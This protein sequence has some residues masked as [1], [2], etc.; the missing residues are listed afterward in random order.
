MLRLKGY[1]ASVLAMILA[2][3]IIQVN[4]SAKTVELISAEENAT[5]VTETPSSD[6]SAY[7]NSEVVENSQENDTELQY[8]VDTEV[9]Q[10]TEQE[11]V[12]VPEEPVQTYAEEDSG[13]IEYQNTGDFYHD[14]ESVL[15]DKGY[16]GVLS[17]DEYGSVML[18]IGGGQGE[19]LALLSQM[20][21]TSAY[22]YQNWNISFDFSGNLSLPDT[23]QGLG[24]WGE[25]SEEQVPFKGKFINQALT[26]TTSKTIF[27][28]LDAS[29]DLHGNSI[30]WE[31]GQNESTPNTPILTNILVA[32]SGDHT[33]N[34]P[35]AYANRFNPYIGKL[36][37][38]SGIVTLPSL[39]YSAVGNSPTVEFTDAVGLICGSLSD[40]THLKIGSLTLPSGSINLKSSQSAGS[41]VGC[42]EE[43][44]T[45][46]ITKD[47][48]INSTING[49][50][51]GGIVGSMT[52]ATINFE[53]NVVI[54]VNATLT[55]TQSAGG[56][57][58]VMSTSSGPLGTNVNVVLESVKAN[59]EQNSG[60]LYGTCAATGE[61]NPLTGVTFG[62]TREVSGSGNCG[63][64][65]GE[66]VLSGDGKCIL[67]GT[68]ETN[69][70]IV[71]T[72]KTA[73]NKTAYGGVAGNLTGA[74]ANAIV[75]NNCNITS[76][77][78]VGNETV[79]YPK[80]LGGIVANQSATLDVKNTTVNVHSPKTFR[81]TD[82]GFGGITAYLADNALL[83]A[84]DT[85]VFTDSYAAN[86]GGGGVVGSAHKG[87]IVYLKTKL[88]LSK[89][90]L[91][92]NATSGQIVGS[93]DSSLIYA[94]TV[95]ITRLD[96]TVDGKNV[97]GMELDDI[98]NYGELYRVDGFLTID[99]AYNTSFSRVLNKTDEQYVLNDKYDYAC[100]AL[101]WQSRGYFPTVEGITKDNWYMSS[102]KSSTIT[103]G[104]DIDLTGC[105]IGGLTRD[106]Y[107]TD[108]TFTG[109]FNGGGY[110]LT[111]D[112]GAANT[113]NT[114]NYGDGRIYW[115]NATG[116]F[117]GLSNDAT[118]QNLTLDGSIRL[119][120]NK[121]S[122]MSSGALAAQVSGSRDTGSLLSKVVTTVEYDTKINGG[123][124]LYLGGLIGQISGG[125]AM[126]SFDDG[127]SLGATINISQTG[128]GSYNHFGGAIGGIT[129]DAS[130]YITCSGATITGNIT[131]TSQNGIT[132]LYAGGLIGTILPSSKP[133]NISINNLT[134]KDFTLTGN[135]KER[136]GG[137]LGGIW[138]DTDVTVDGLNV[139]DTTLLTASGTAELGGLVYRA[140]GKWTVS[141]VNLY[142]LTIDASTAG[143]LGILVCHGN[144]Y[145]DPI[146][147]SNQNMNGLYLEMVEH[148][149]WNKTTKKG[150]V[151]PSNIKFGS[152]IFD[153]FVAY[154]AYA[155][156]A[157]DTP[158]YQITSNG[159]GIIS[160]KTNNDTV[161]MTDDERNT[162]VNQTNI[163]KHTN[164]YSRYYYN[165]DSIMSGLNDANDNKIDTAKE[166][167]IW[168]VCRY[169]DS[170]LRKHFKT[171]GIS[172]LWKMTT[173]G[174]TSDS[175]ANFDM[176]GLSYYPINIMNESINV[177]YSNVVFY[178][179]K[180][181]EKENGNK[182]TLATDGIY[183]QHYTMH[184]GLFHDF[185][186][187]SITKTEDYVITVNG[188][189][190]VGTVGVVN[191]GSG[192]LICGIVEGLNNGTNVAICKVV[193]SDEDN[194]SKA[195]KLNGISVSS[196]DDYCPVM[197]N[198]FADYSALES[199][200]IISEQYDPAGSSLFGK[201]EKSDGNAATSI[202][203]LLEGTLKLCE[204]KD[205]VFSK[206][207]LFHSLHYTD[208]S[209][210]YN[211]NKDKD[212]AADSTYV[213]NAT[214]GKE[215]NEGV[216]VEYAG[217]QGNY[218][219]G[220]P[221]T[222]EGN[223]PEFSN[224]LPYVAHSPATNKDDYKL[225][226]NWHEIAVNVR[227]TDLTDGCGTYGHPFLVDASTLTSV[228]NYINNGRASNGWR[229][230]VPLNLESAQYHI[231]ENDSYDVIVIYRNG[232]FFKGETEYTGN[233]REYLQSAIYQIKED[234]TLNN[235]GG[236]G[237]KDT[238]DVAFK[239]VIYGNNHTITLSGGTSA[240]IKYSYGSVVRDMNIV[241]GNK[242][243]LTR[244]EPARPN[245]VTEAKRS[246]E[247]F[248][249][250]VIGSVLGGDNIIEN[251]TVS[252]SSFRLAMTDTADKTYLIPIGG[253]VGA[254]NGGGVIFRGNCSSDYTGDDN[255]Y[256]NPFVG[257]VL[258]GYA[259]YEG[260]DT[261][262]DNGNDKDYQNYK[263]NQI[264]SSQNDLNWDSSTS[265][266]TVNTARGLLILSA[267]VSSGAGSTQSVA[268][269]NGVAR[270]AAYDKI[271]KS[272]AEAS[273]D[274]EKAKLDKAATA[275]YLLIKF[276][277]CA[278]RVNIC[279]N[280]T[281][282]ITIKIAQGANSEPKT[283]NMNDY[284]NGYRGLSARY[285]SNAA[286]T[287][288]GVNASTVVMRVKTFDGQNATVQNINMNVKEYYDDDFHMA[289]M[290]GIFNIVW[291]QKK[292][293]GGGVGSNFAQNLTLQNCNVSLTYVDSSG[294]EQNEAAIGT[295][296]NEDGRRA[297]SVGGFIGMA[298][299]V[300]AAQDS[301]NHNY[302]L[303]NIHIKGN[304][305]TSPCVIVGPNSTGGLIGATAM[306]T[307][308][309]AGYPG[310]LLANGKWA[311]FGPSFLN[312]SYRDIKV[313]GILAAG[314]L[315]GDAY[316]STRDK[317]PNFN[318][319]GISY[320]TGGFKAYTSCTVTNA[321]LKVGENATITATAKG[322]IAGGLFGGAGMRVG[323]N[324]PEVNTKSG[325]S[326][327]SNVHNIQHL[328][329]ESINIEISTTTYNPTSADSP[330]NSVNYAYA[331]GLIGRIGSVNPSCFY[332][333][334][335]NG[336]SV[337]SKYATASRV[338]GI[339]GSG[340]TN[341]EI[342]MERCEISS[343][344]LSGA[345][346]GGFLGNGQDPPGFKLNMSD[347]K[348]ENSSV[349]GSSTAGG[350]VGD[351]KS[352]YYLHNILIKNTSIT[353]NK[354]SVGRLFGK[355]TINSAGDNF[356][357][358]AA[359]ISV[360]A[361]KGGI[362]IP[363]KDGVGDNYNG[364]IAYSDY[365]GI[366][367]IVDVA[368]SPYVTVNPNYTL[369]GGDKTLYGDA[370]GKIQ[371]DTYNSV[372]ARIWADSITGAT[373]IK[374]L[375]PYVN[376]GA[377]VNATGK[378]AP[379]VST[380]KEIQG[381]S[382]GEWSLTDLP[383]LV[384][385][386]NDASAIED[387]LNVITNGGY[388]VAK[389]GGKITMN[390]NSVSTYY[391][392]KESGIFSLA[393]DTQLAT[394]PASIFYENG[395]FNVRSRAF[396]NTLD[397]FSLVEVNFTVKVNGKDKTYTVSL[398]VVVI[399]ELQYDYM[400]TFSYGK[401]FMPSTYD[402]IKTHL[403]ESTGNPFTVYL[404]YQY[405]REKGDYREYDWQTY[406]DDGGSMLAI[407]KVLHFSSGLPAGTQMILMDCQK[408]NQAYQFTTTNNNSNDVKMSEFTS[409]IDGNKFQSSMADVLGVTSDPSASGKFV[410]ADKDSGTV[411]LKGTYYRLYKEET[412][413]GKVRY[414]LT[415]PDLSA[416]VP[417]ENYYL[418][419]T[420]PDQNDA[421]YYINGVLTSSLSWTMPSSGTK[422]HR[423]STEN[424][425]DDSNNTESTYQI[426]T[427]YR[428]TLVSTTGSEKIDLNTPSN[429]MQVKLQDTITFSNQQVY[430]DSDQLFLKFTANLKEHQ[431][432]NA[433]E[434]QFP[435][436]TSGTVKFYVRDLATNTY[437]KWDTASGKWITSSEKTVSTSYL[438]ESN[439][440][441][442]ELLLSADGQNALD[443]AA[444]RQA[445][446][447]N[448]NEGESNI[449]ITAEMDMEFG[450][451]V[452]LE[453]TV[454]GS[455]KSGT[456]IWAQMHYISQIS[457]QETSIGYSSM[458]AKVDDNV[459]YYRGVTY[460]A[461][462]SMDAAN[463]D[464]LGV[465]PLQL[466]ENYQETIG[467]KNASRIDL[468]AVLDLSNLQN[469][470]S[471]L[472]STDSITFSLSLSIRNDEEY[473]SVDD[474]VNYIAFKWNDSESTGLSWTISKEKYY[475]DNSV[476]TSEI[477]DGTQFSFPIT[478]Y[479]FTDKK[480]FANYKINLSVSFDGM[481]QQPDLNY[482][483]A[484]VVY[485]YACI[486]PTFYS[487][488]ISN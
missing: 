116:L 110:T 145:K 478:A 98:G 114:V 405:N 268:Y 300:D 94:P 341:S 330:D 3:N 400:A 143:A 362:I 431:G 233:V 319:L 246:P 62:D 150:Y 354:T 70:E 426:S 11:V 439:G 55:A 364:Y 390:E 191:V 105:G 14:F 28:A 112:I 324:D 360:Y 200:Y 29:A 473:I 164:M 10:I 92:T 123:N 346:A 245:G 307:E 40:N 460:Q 397:R 263:I 432:G 398:P 133:R 415:V 288:S 199:N 261:V 264:D 379:E 160:L 413:A 411:R 325:I 122:P 356:G 82:Y 283:L 455:D 174:G 389:S 153:E 83:V 235:F 72:L 120:N 49:L 258:G 134:V 383:V 111:L 435:V 311:L 329:L 117:A 250:G 236:I 361:D 408:G 308:K 371:G 414:D 242:P 454:P 88:D 129:G 60:V 269:T 370:V 266:L 350:L 24:D 96:D 77:V 352:F 144:P 482:S 15:N 244:T 285:V 255:Y 192:A 108:D 344:N 332:D 321:D 374:N 201:V 463:I 378:T 148:W 306:A 99:A 480:N 433:E 485:T 421:E 189:S 53:D 171:S 465:N 254:I 214:Y 252:A 84:E 336:G 194:V 399:R 477:F 456:D 113:A 56:I 442:M 61:F 423:Y 223:T 320:N 425:I 232:K 173:I 280:D 176:G 193:L 257:R 172:E 169:A 45:L 237:T 369:N 275:S 93:Q 284:G 182:S 385:K 179:N 358:Y 159:S 472:E 337:T 178:N 34:M 158:N 488:S 338:G 73:S 404:T 475:M 142:G 48:T 328:Y 57:T 146:N 22:N 127:S 239:G 198:R 484:N 355:I 262:P 195:V 68:Q 487:F 260:D 481:Q 165:L 476:T 69:L 297:V 8:S 102:I 149:N 295:F 486:K 226:N 438:W 100:F 166:L 251:V 89:C 468:N 445:I 78:D 196:N 372:A 54:T 376:A 74:R 137:I 470:E 46:T 267:I 155:D 136:M 167:L 416:S 217:L 327:V 466:V 161:N 243:S 270:N 380:F 229:L 293:G 33:I 207:T 434:R 382:D 126:I 222:V 317:I 292:S 381:Y 447:G 224:Y 124:V 76:T 97:K 449:V 80:Y 428:Q 203:I 479:V 4:I 63:G 139:N 156:R 219:D 366:E 289:S 446:K 13:T 301:I 409:L 271:G 35:L 212:Y 140:S 125:V 331:A 187:E 218:L 342:T 392:G 215:L 384:L 131:S 365:S 109:S 313:T 290:G 6:Q 234:I 42:M 340:Y 177:Q 386:G 227:F 427:G 474:S 213:H 47:L 225:E 132:N 18:T 305:N 38:G 377:I 469:V 453:A 23:F 204:T 90:Q 79:N 118:V 298:N 441:N 51:S 417:T 247:T 37:D 186:S 104:G 303:S 419:I 322:S 403:L 19:I 396:D 410:V 32:G 318:G 459:G 238:F 429:K 31:I 444:V 130:T 461:I 141:S 230:R 424:K 418:V 5:E 20:S 2:I 21:Q 106:L 64:L 135:A 121:K 181:E 294:T 272:E 220:D 407:D 276:S 248:F 36:I 373:G 339:Q 375:A 393:T 87:S 209:A 430:G 401:E 25:T 240:L 231:N 9:N 363:E 462:L 71:S 274:F 333:V 388:G 59:G 103:L 345:N 367:T 26:I 41:L 394:N 259:F 458:R 287:S 450:T 1:I 249:G 66:L 241:L 402:N 467:E 278:N 452:V 443:L 483:D 277:N 101:A 448:K 353:G 162:Y 12:T 387:Y 335:I 175:Y 304:S 302:L 180:I 128:N 202:S 52:N 157:N 357:V 323:V 188:V 151:V 351:A 86:P 471:L 296:A 206:A 44:A 170:S 95:S 154:T 326:I 348:L 451:S 391:Y 437:Y 265:T 334:K 138:A 395:K 65:F 309:V 256:N 107:L 183:T 184:C 205:K 422:L 152:G 286:Y 39:D 282:G 168:A 115:H 58:G 163:G 273:V 368:N 119:S 27:K 197:I 50:N 185:K 279:T 147:G 291:T 315:V 210:S 314:G 343:F 359:G 253:F 412:D 349:I 16:S 43:N 67:S 310:K 211:F 464:Q 420:V 7:D 457:T 216:S 81:G 190:F 208:G 312:C 75:V 85:T 316:T 30:K 347:C 406:M 228:A 299:D 91:S 440:G 221:I 281:E 17:K 436:G